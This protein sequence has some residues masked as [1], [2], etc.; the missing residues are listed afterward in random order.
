MFFLWGI[1]SVTTF[2]CWILNIFIFLESQWRNKAEWT[3]FAKIVG[4]HLCT[5]AF[6]VN[7]IIFGF[8][9]FAFTQ[10][11]FKNFAN[12]FRITEVLWPNLPLSFFCETQ[13]VFG[14]GSSNFLTFLTNTC[15]SLKAKRWAF[16]PT[17]LVLRHTA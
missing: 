8:S 1:K 6:K 3:S 14:L 9:S 15:A 16:I 17:A 11:V 7:L 10:K 2:N 12:I 5:Y 4:K 13:R